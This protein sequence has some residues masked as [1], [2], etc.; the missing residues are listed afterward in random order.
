MIN[1]RNVKVVNT[2]VERM[3]GGIQLLCTGDVVLDQVTVLESGDFSFDVS[4]TPGSKIEMKNCRGDVAYNPLFNLTRGDLPKKGFYEV[5]ILSPPEGSK[6]TP[7]SGLGIIC[8]DECE[9]I[10]RDGLERPLPEEA[11]FLICGGRKKLVDSK[12]ENFTTAR[13][14]LEKNVENCRIRSRGEVEDRGKG[15][16][17]EKIE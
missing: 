1:V 12:I 9:F 5:T 7:R 8:G 10:L 16:R 11:N 13:L 6:P 17:V 15:N 4:A 3:R 14:V 2:T